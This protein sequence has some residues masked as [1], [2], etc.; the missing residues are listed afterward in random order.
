MSGQSSASLG[1][2]QLL[3]GHKN[4]FRIDPVMPPHRFGLD[5]LREIDS[6]RGLGESEARK[7]LPQLKPIFFQEAA[8]P[9]VPYYL[10]ALEAK[11]FA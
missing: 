6:L 4:V 2:A 1:T 3:A 9:F 11:G 10:E 7:A 8:E 5:I